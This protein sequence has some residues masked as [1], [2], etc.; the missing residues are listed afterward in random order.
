M[1]RLDGSF[2]YSASDLNAYLDCKRLVELEALVARRKLVRPDDKDEQAKLLRR[3][4]EAHEAAHLAALQAIYAGEEIAAFHERPQN[5]RDGY[6]RAE[7]ATVEAMR[8]GVPV[9]YQA[10]FFDGTFVG[11]ADFLRRVENPSDLGDFSYEAVDTKL[12][13]NPKPYY[14]VQLCNY[15]EHLE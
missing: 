2:V 13:L 3:K 11:R 14:L 5:S 10:T 9:L 1:Q 15:T 12:G 7:A 6:A 4:G 8:R